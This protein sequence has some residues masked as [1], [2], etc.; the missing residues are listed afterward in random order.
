MTPTRV[1]IFTPFK[2]EIRNAFCSRELH[3]G[4]AI[5]FGII[6]T[7]LVVDE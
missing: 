6:S 4:Y 5:N 1:N 7:R 2:F 3:V